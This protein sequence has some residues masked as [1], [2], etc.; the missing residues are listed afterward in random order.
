MY[1]HTQTTST[2]FCVYTTCG[3]NMPHYCRKQL[4]GCSAGWLLGG[5]Y[6]A[7]WVKLVSFLSMVFRCNMGPSV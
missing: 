5:R 3:A 1:V 4:L 6:R 2:R 7:C